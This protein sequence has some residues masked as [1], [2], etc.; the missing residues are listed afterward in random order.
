MVVV[1]VLVDLVVVG[2]CGV[3]LVGIDA[4]T[5]VVAVVVGV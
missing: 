2:W 1:V 4:V 5:V 3:V